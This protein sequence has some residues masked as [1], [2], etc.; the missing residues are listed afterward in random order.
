[1]EFGVLEALYHKGPLTQGQIGERILLTSGSITAVVDKLEE[2]GLVERR[3]CAEDRRVVYADL[4]DEGREL[5][6]RV[7]PEHAEALRIAMEGLTTEEKRIAAVLLVRLGRHA[8]SR[9]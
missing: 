3:P 6:A 7:F 4:T 1:M 8:A 5:I 2:R 9:R